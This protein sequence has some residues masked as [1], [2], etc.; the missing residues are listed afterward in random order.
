MGTDDRKVAVVTGASAG[1]GAAAARGLA[2]A[3]YCVIVGARRA[4]PLEALAREIGGVAHPLDVTDPASVAAF[5]AAVPERL[6]LLVNNAGG[7]HGLAPVAQASDDDW[8]WMFEAN[9][10]SVMRMTRALLPRL[11]ATRGH[12]VNVT[13]IAGREV[14]PGGAGYTAAKH[15]A[16]ALTR[17]LRLELNGRPVRVTD[18]A[19][20]L[21]ETEFSLVRF[22][23][24]AERAAKVYEGLTPLTAGDIAD[25]IVWAATRPAH[26]NIDEIVVKPVAQASATV[27][28]RGVGL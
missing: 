6:H 24:D 3:G 12:V 20:G 18:I 5:C 11:E 8:V 26:V 17:T 10:L 16:V 19:P 4:G 9:V 14:Y 25:C 21:V 22:A 2:A 13:S 7:A 28:A 1:I 27:A 23:G 15:A